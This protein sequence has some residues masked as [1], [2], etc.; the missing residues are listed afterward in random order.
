[1]ILGTK[2]RQMSR[3]EGGT[4]VEHTDPS[5]LEITPRIA[6]PFTREQPKPREK[7]AADP[8]K[9]ICS[10]AGR[11]LFSGAHLPRRSRARAGSLVTVSTFRRSTTAPPPPLS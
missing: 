1:M 9:V 8:M 3:T 10:P 11:N 6:R 7:V 4:L 5:L 2:T